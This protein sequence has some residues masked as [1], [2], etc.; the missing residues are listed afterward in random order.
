MW[1]ADDRT[2]LLHETLSALWEAGFDG[3]D[4]LLVPQPLACSESLRLLLTEKAWGSLLRQWICNP[5]A[6][7]VPA[8]TRVADWLA[9]LHRTQSFVNRNLTTARIIE[10]LK[11][12]QAELTASAEPWL[13]HERG[14]IGSL[15][16]ELMTRLRESAPDE[17]CLIH[18]DFHAENILLRGSTVTVIDF[19][20]C[21]TG[22]PACDPGYQI[23]QLD[24]QS[25]RYWSRRGRRSPHDISRLTQI[26]CAQY[27]R[28]Q[29][30]CVLGRVPLYQARTYLKHLLYTLRM[31]GTEQPHQVTLWL[32]K[33]AAC[34]ATGA[35]SRSQNA[36][37]A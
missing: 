23:G 5:H 37:A 22:D 3:R 17:L 36:N 32:D 20:H 35:V 1:R 28:T 34:L 8:L 18:G 21:V 31:K 16:A 11:Q 13:R 19:E 30:E 12:W 15:L 4:G 10:D 27:C 33:A 25:D 6:R 9:R 29:P 24:L 26:I 2:E 14:R 7:W